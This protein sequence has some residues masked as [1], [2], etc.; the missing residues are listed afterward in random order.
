MFDLFEKLKDSPRERAAFAAALA[1]TAAIGAV[2]FY[3]GP[4]GES[5]KIVENDTKAVKEIPVAGDAEGPFEN[6]RAELADAAVF[7]AGQVRRIGGFWKQF[8]FGK[9]MEYERKKQEEN[10]PPFPSLLQTPPLPR[11]P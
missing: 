7:L 11:P 6:F 4:R 5:A 2:W 3:L 8:D 9:P 1:L 10:T